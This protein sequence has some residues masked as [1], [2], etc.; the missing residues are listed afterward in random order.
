MNCLDFLRYARLFISYLFGNYILLNITTDKVTLNKVTKYF[1][2]H[3][4]ESL[5]YNN[6]FNS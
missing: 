2:I 6:L 4:L 5:S 1:F 3:H